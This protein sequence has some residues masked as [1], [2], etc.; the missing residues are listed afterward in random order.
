MCHVIILLTDH[1]NMSLKDYR[2][3]VFVSFGS[4]LIDHDVVNMILLKR[5]VMFFCEIADVITD[6]FFVAGATGNS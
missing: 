5:K 3:T 2:S 4:R 1:V 6:F